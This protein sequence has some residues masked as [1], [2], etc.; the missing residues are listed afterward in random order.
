MSLSYPP[1]LI[2]GLLVAAALIIGAVLAG[3][4]R[5]AALAAAGIS[6]AG[7]R[8]NQLGLW[9]S[10][11]GVVLLAVAWP[12][13]PLRCRSAGAPARSSWRWTFPTA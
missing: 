11:G 3:R 5:S 9:L 12:A 7:R 8:N 6:A 10:V 13:R 1:L 2:L 4:R